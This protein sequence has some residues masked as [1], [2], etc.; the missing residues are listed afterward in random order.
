MS[1]Q[2]RVRVAP[3]PT[4]DPHVGTAYIAL[5]NA[6]FAMMHQG[7]FILRIEDTDQARSRPQYEKAIFDA[8]HWCGL[9]WDEGPDVGGPCGPY[10]QSERKE[11]YQRHCHQL[12][13]RG[14]AYPCFATAEELEEMRMIA[15]AQGKWV[16]YNRRD[17]N[18]SKEEV[19]RRVTAGEP[20]VIRLKV[21]L[22]GE[23]S[24]VDGVRG[25]VSFQ[26]SEV[27]DQVLLKSDGMPTYHLANVVDDHLMDI[28]HVIRGEEWISSTPKHLCLYQAFG[29]EPP[30]FIHMPLILSPNGQKLSKRKNPTSI[31]YYRDMGYVPEALMNFL[32]LMGY[33][34]STQEEVYS[35]DA[36][37]R[38]FSLERVGRSS[39][40]FDSQKLDWLNQQHLMHDLSHEELWQRI[41]EWALDDETMKKLMPL[42]ATRIT[43]FSDFIPSV[44]FLLSGDLTY[45][46]A[47]LAVKG[48]SPKQ[49]ACLL[50]AFMYALEQEE[51]WDKDGFDR[52]SRST[53]AQY[54]VH[55]RKQV[56]PLLF[57]VITGSKKSIPLFASI[58]FLGK[59]RARARMKNA[60][61]ALGGLTQKEERAVQ[62][63]LCQ[64]TTP[65]F[66]EAHTSEK[67]RGE[68]STSSQLR[69][70]T[71]QRYTQ[72][73]T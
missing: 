31:F 58:N 68:K 35:W 65:A 8:M 50:Y 73:Q 45:T 4:G 17:R 51:A 25:E 7:V 29:W 39:A 18:L 41:K 5:F 9:S 52:L 27:D 61:D 22:E 38:D 48:L 19:Q 64:G 71:P 46:D 47:D 16:G 72:K 56:M 60:I 30:Q 28:S 23:C 70:E 67:Q 20:H 14:H 53:A 13:E 21:P 11:I 33:T 54:G 24:F 55:H 42:V 2:V 36:I 63:S 3:S 62:E 66:W 57:T 32:S 10:R 43:K 6:L 37:A 59:D 40:R 69:G 49:V 34:M 12:V 26:W 15:R 1:R 44:A